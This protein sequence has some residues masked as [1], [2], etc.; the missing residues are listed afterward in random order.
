MS[1]AAE[2]LAKHPAKGLYTLGALLINALKLPLWIFYHLSSS[3]RQHSRWSLRQAVATR[4]LRTALWHFSFMRVNTPLILQ[5]TAKEKGLLVT[6]PPSTKGG[7]YMGICDDE[8]VKPE[9]I[10]G[11]WYPS[12]FN[13]DEDRGKKIVLHFHGGAYWRFGGWESGRDA[14]EIS[15]YYECIWTCCGAFVVAL[16]GSGE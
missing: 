11:Y 8:E 3:T 10:C 2:I 16:G 14:A 9:K 15:C 6:I 12:A 1:T 5:P 13:E 4:A 7:V